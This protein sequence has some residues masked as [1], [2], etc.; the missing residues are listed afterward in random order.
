MFN[1]FGNDTFL[2]L[3][4]ELKEKYGEWLI[5]QMRSENCRFGLI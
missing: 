5:P 1:V 2:S 3:F 4:T